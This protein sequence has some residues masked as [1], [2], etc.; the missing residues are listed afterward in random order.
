MSETT[1]GP[2]EPLPKFRA[3]PKSIDRSL[4]V[5]IVMVIV[6]GV[7]CWFV[8]VQE[9]FMES[10]SADLVMMMKIVP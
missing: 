6:A 10:F 2:Q 9:A 5:M 1:K 3:L 7:A 4:I 8:E